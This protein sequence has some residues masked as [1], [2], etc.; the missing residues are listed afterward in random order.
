MDTENRS[1]PAGAQ[2][3]IPAKNHPAGHRTAGVVHAH[4]RHTENFTVIGNDPAQHPE[5]S[6]LAIG[7]ACYVQPGQ[8]L[9][10]QAA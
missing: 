8:R 4:V 1:A 9:G 7:L 10:H 2:P 6:L 3:R 5:L